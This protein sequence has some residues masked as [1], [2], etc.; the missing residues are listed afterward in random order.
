M[1]KP[2]DCAPAKASPVKRRSFQT[3]KKACHKKWPFVTIDE[4]GDT[5]LNSDVRSTV[6]K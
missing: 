2:I 4:K 1:A 6:V 5:C 3:L